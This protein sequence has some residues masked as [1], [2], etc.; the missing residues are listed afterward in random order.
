MKYDADR[1]MRLTV[2]GFKRLAPKVII[3][4]LVTCI[5]YGF[6]A[7]IFLKIYKNYF[8]YCSGVNLATATMTITD[9]VGTT[10]SVTIDTKQDCL[11]WGGSW[12]DYRI[13]PD[14]FGQSLLYFMLLASTEGWTSLMIPAASL[15]G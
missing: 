10:T 2:V 5:F 4:L 13:S 1:N 6:F 8:S 14:N 15:R 9:S 11:I 7:L 12:V 3:L